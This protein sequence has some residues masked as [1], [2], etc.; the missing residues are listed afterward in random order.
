MTEFRH[1]E[2][3]LAPVDFYREQRSVF[4]AEAARAKQRG[5]IR[6][7]ARATLNVGWADEKLGRGIDGIRRARRAHELF[8]DAGDRSGAAECLHSI[9]VWTFHN[10]TDV[11]GPCHDFTVAANERWDVGETLLAAQSLHNRGYVEM[12]S[13]RVAAGRSSY[14]QANTVLDS[15]L[16]SEDPDAAR[17]AERQRG[18]VLSHVAYWHALFGTIGDA[19]KVTIAYFD[20]VSRTGTHREPVL[21]YLAAAHA[22]TRLDD[23]AMSAE[24]SAQTAVSGIEHAFRTAVVLAASELSNPQPGARRAYLGSHL[25]ALSDFAR[26]LSNGGRSDAARATLEFAIDLS[27]ARHWAG[28]TARLRQVARDLS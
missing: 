6:D 24:L 19:I 11:D 26:W 1:D 14:D 23:S 8:L 13:G 2:L 9:A 16:H 25:L 7:E 27:L 28:E 5:A 22:M 4:L 21:A 18:F 10:T 12:R 17:S 20:H 15:A 3:G